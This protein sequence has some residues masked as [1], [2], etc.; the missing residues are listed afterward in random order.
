V[1]FKLFYIPFIVFLISLAIFGTR[2]A[3]YRCNIARVINKAGKNG[4]PILVCSGT[5]R[6]HEALAVYTLDGSSAPLITSNIN[7][8][9][10]YGEKFFDSD[11]TF[12]IAERYVYRF[13]F[14]A[15]ISTRSRISHWDTFVNLYKPYSTH[16]GYGK[17]SWVIYDFTTPLEFKFVD[18]V[19]SDVAIFPLKNAPP[20]AEAAK[21]SYEVRFF[22][23]QTRDYLF[24]TET[25]LDVEKRDAGLEPYHTVELW[26]YNIQSGEWSHIIDGGSD[27]R[28]DVDSD[29]N[30]ACLQLSTHS[31]KFID[32]TSGDV[33]MELEPS[34]NPFFGKRWFMCNSFI[35]DRNS[36]SFPLVL[37]DLENNWEKYVVN[38]GSGFSYALYEPPPDGL[39]G[40]GDR[41]K[42]NQR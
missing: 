2:T 16:I 28:F 38:I 29:G 21:D 13:R 24:T 40:M 12:Y 1:K 8:Y 5:D 6:R 34:R 37:F 3:I 7:S 23:R 4:W 11:G 22:V 36:R 30:Y 35:I 31:L 33:F 9:D 17:A 39:A 42:H 10:L 20:W 27:V 32:L 25:H 14:P 19:S 15:C 18:M 26:K 41:W